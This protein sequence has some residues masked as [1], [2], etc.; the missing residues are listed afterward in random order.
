MTPTPCKRCGSRS[1]A[2]NGACLP[3]KRTNDRNRARANRPRST[4][5]ER[6]RKHGVIPDLQSKPGVPLNHIYWIAYYFMDKQVDVIRLMGDVYDLPSLSSYDKRGS[7][8]V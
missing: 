3:C 8:S 7:K 4:A 6:G 5:G 2:A 1:K